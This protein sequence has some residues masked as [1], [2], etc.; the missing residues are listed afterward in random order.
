MRAEDFLDLARVDIRAAADD[1][2]LLAVR[3][4]EVAVLV[5]EAHVTRVVPAVRR[6]SAV[7]SGWFQ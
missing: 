6:V 7:A 4:V 3:N 2:V 1:Q 5:Q